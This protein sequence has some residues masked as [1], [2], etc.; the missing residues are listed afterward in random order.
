MHPKKNVIK[1]GISINEKFAVASIHENIATSKHPIALSK[2][3]IDFT[4]FPPI[5]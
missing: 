1:H 3:F 5:K 2:S 4:L